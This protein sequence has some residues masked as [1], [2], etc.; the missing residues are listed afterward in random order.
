MKNFKLFH[1]PDL[2]FPLHRVTLLRNYPSVIK[3][4]FVTIILM[5]V[6]L[7]ALEVLVFG[8]KE[9]DNGL[10][11]NWII[12]ITVTPLSCYSNTFKAFASKSNYSIP[13][14]PLH[15]YLDILGGGIL[16]NLVM[17]VSLPAA[18]LAVKGLTLLFTPGY[19]IRVF[20]MWQAIW[21]GILESPIILVCYLLFFS[22]IILSDTLARHEGVKLLLTL[23]AIALLTA[24]AMVGFEAQAIAVPLGLMVFV[25][26][27]VLSYQIFKRWQPA[28]SGIWMI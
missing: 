18:E 5:A 23:A 24:Y 28:N 10:L 26:N 3:H 12:M 14:S 7:Y 19:D 20:A 8:H 6:G 27:I 15:K 4:S 1:S 13:I 9:S 22:F 25:A 17:L 2:E 16:S 11:N 21:L